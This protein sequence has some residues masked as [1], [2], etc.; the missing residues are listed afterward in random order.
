MARRQRK[1]LCVLPGDPAKSGRTRQGHLH[2]PLDRSARG[3]FEEF[4]ENDQK[5]IDEFVDFGFGP[6]GSAK[7]PPSGFGWY[8]RVPSRITEAV[9]HAD[10]FAPRIQRRTKSRR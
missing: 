8:V 5:K 3:P 10:E 2:I 9:E 6:A 4:T 7:V 1:Q